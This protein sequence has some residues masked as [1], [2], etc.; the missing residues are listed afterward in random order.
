MTSSTPVRWR[1]ERLT[2]PE[3][4]VSL[5]D[6]A[7]AAAV[8]RLP[9]SLVGAVARRYIAGETLE[10]ALSL[11]GRLNALGIRT[12]M[13]VLGENITRVAEAD[14]T[15]ALYRD[16]LR[17]LHARG[18]DG[19]ISVKLTHLG[20][21]LDRKRC[22]LNVRT[23]VADAAALGNFVRIDMEDSSTTSD[24]LDIYR[25]MR[26]THSNLGVVLQAYMKRSLR[27]AED[28]ARM[29]ARVRVC[30]GIYREP[31]D[32]AYHDRERINR[33]FLE[34][35]DLL[36]DRGSHVAIATHDRDVVAGAEAI[37]AR[38]GGCSGQYEFQMLLG[39]AERLRD[40]LVAGKHPVR[41]YV[42]FGRE[43]YAYS[44]RRLRENPRIAG[45]VLR[46]LAGGR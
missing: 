39:V 12:T 24:T 37:L 15:V 46:A 41:V 19:N 20:L 14:P 40:S 27:D 25:E 7:I 26:E 43:W 9:R 18:L 34:I 21:K 16:V 28:L 10:T 44:V 23:L 3:S 2:A 36:L 1:T 6:R 11:T 31:A 29:G 32:I 5:F 8:P 17:E 35:V 45:H 38:R 30:K 4:T 33:S 42:P 22:A 13:D